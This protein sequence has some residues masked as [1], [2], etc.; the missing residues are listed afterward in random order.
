MTSAE[1]DALL[2]S[3]AHRQQLTSAEAETI[4]QAIVAEPVTT[5][6]SATWWSELTLR[7]SERI[8]RATRPRIPVFD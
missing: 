5:L 8:V 4:R 3:W 2:A 1:L 6:E 7:M